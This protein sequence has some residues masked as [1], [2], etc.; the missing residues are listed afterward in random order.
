[1][2]AASRRQAFRV[3]A[4]VLFHNNRQPM[5]R[6]FLLWTVVLIWDAHELVPLSNIADATC[7]AG[8]CSVMGIEGL[9]VREFLY[10]SY[11]S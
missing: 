9:W 4:P 1:M 3:A 6:L 11:H 7:F 8:G 5:Q 2:R 10:A